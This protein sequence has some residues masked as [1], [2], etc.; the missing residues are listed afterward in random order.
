MS[1]GFIYLPPRSQS[2]VSHSS[3]EPQRTM[4]SSSSSLPIIADTR[5]FV[6]WVLFC[7]SSFPLLLSCRRMYNSSARTPSQLLSAGKTPAHVA[8][9]RAA[10]Q[11]LDCAR[12]LECASQSQHR[13]ATG[14]LPLPG[15][16]PHQNET[17]RRK[18]RRQDHLTWY[19]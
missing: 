12:E 18:P 5:F 9:Q 15:D 8:S 1:H 17:P 6:R 2:R 4:H 10:S 11:N 13:K 3:T 16:Q 14:W 7:F 19:R